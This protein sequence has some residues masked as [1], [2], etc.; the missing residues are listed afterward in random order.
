MGSTYSSLILILAVANAILVN[1]TV[2][3]SLPDPSTGNNIT[4]VASEGEW[5]SGLTCGTCK[6]TINVDRMHAKTWHDS[7]NFPYYLK[8]RGPPNATF[9]FN[10]TA[11]YVFCAIAL[12]T[13]NPIGYSDMRF[14][15]DGEIV[16]NYTRIPPA[17]QDYEYNVPVYSNT[18][19]LP[20][21]HIFMLQNGPYPAQEGK[22]TL[23]LLDYIVYS[24]VNKAPNPNCK[25]NSIL[26]F[27]F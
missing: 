18:T 3:D 1:V 24:H 23:I 27:W 10:G 22:E 25:R 26:I 4:Y 21:P 13:I 15:I 19:L 20:G 2:D 5:I 7:T 9:T 8:P 12:S 11:I 14:Y 16:G 6:A 17:I